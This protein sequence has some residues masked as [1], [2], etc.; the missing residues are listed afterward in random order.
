[1]HT[2]QGEPQVRFLWDVLATVQR[3]FSRRAAARAALWAASGGLTLL[4]ALLIADAAFAFPP[5]ARLVVYPAAVLVGLAGAA[6]SAYAAG[7]RKPSLFYVA[8]LIEQRRPELK[9]DLVTFLELATD[10]ET[11]PSLS[12]AV[13]RRAARMLAGPIGS[14]SGRG[15]EAPA[16]L[17]PVGW[18][19]PLMAAGGAAFCLAVTLWLA[20]GIVIRPGPHWTEAAIA[21]SEGSA[22]VS[23]RD[24]TPIY[25]GAEAG[26]APAPAGKIEGSPDGSLP[27]PAPPE[28][29]AATSATGSNAD[30]NRETAEVDGSGGEG[31]AEAFAAALAQRCGT[32]EA[33]TLQRLAAALGAET[34]ADASGASSA[35]S[36]DSEG[37][38]GDAVPHPAT[39]T[40]PNPG[41]AS[42]AETGAEA[43][44]AAGADGNSEDIQAGAGGPPEGSGSRAGAQARPP[45]AGLDAGG[46]AAGDAEREPG[47]GE[48]GP[49][50]SG[51]A[52]GPPI[53]ER[54]PTSFS[55]KPLDPVRWAEQLIREAD[56]RLREGEVNDAFLGRMGMSRADFRRFVTAW[57]RRF[58]VAAGPDATPEPARAR[59]AAGADA[60]EL[61]QATGDAAARTIVDAG[62]PRAAPS[63]VVEAELG[64]VRGRFRPVVRAYLE[65][66]GQLAAEAESRQP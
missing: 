59:T 40:K 55:D 60:G 49:G 53:G 2:R 31:D 12:A 16:L 46:S 17:A 3:A 47:T 30:G 63:E 37:G 19:R 20:Q 41:G 25:I 11:E 21:R 9:N 13:G 29:E 8:R 33:E 24:A 5:D 22:P 58:D 38:R 52:S 14:P 34:G 57:R 64:G 39:G 51:S 66:V 65:R 28:Q 44:S 6:G 61:V 1:V 42:D 54:P 50:R 23:S 7:A 10:P 56:E 18:R 35:I 15:I 43:G 27:S 48:S 32:K 26:S 36:P 4:A 62:P 45:G